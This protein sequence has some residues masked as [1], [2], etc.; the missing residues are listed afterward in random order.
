MTGRFG[1]LYGCQVVIPSSAG[2]VALAAYLKTREGPVTLGE[3][4]SRK[5]AYCGTKQTVD[6]CTSC[7][8]PDQT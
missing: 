8:A 4:T 2:F 3:A 6:R 7:G 1:E 5:C